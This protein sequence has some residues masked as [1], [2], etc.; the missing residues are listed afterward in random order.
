MNLDS[1]HLALLHLRV[2]TKMSVQINNY[3]ART[4]GNLSLQSSKSNTKYIYY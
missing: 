4:P 1:L 3:F 2:L